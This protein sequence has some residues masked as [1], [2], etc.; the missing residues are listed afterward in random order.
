MKAKK[1]AVVGGD[2]R[3]HH[4]LKILPGR[5]FC[6]TAHGLYMGGETSALDIL[7]D[8]E[9]VIFGLPM[10]SCDGKISAPLLKNP[11]ELADAF[12]HITP[13]TMVFGG[14]IPPE[15]HILAKQF[16]FALSD[17]S[18]REEFA[19]RNA[20]LTA[21]GAVEIALCRCEQSLYGSRCVILGYGRIG[22]ALTDLLLAF[23]ARV[24]V[25]ARSPADLEWISRSGA[26]SAKYSTLNSQ[27]PFCEIIF[28]TVPS[29]LLDAGRLAF[30]RPGCKVIDLA[31]AP[32]GVDLIAANKLCINAES[33]LS[34]PGKHSPVSA[35][36]IILDTIENILTERGLLH[37]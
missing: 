37:D 27:L 34:L 17:Y 4:L 23:G 11:P 14:N 31:S 15:A 30:L 9:I 25:C 33:A 2:L 5:S 6:G 13:G 19:V 8:C 29:I 10:L 28:N 22:K 12:S 24:T 32:G 35:G 7:P 21:E 16:N 3:L 1:I 36:E 26:A 18:A 20:I